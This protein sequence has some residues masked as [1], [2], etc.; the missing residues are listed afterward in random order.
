MR[1]KSLMLLSLIIALI[2]QLQLSACGGGGGGG[3]APGIPRLMIQPDDGRAPILAAIDGAMNN[4][5]LTIYE[6]TD[7]KAVSQNPAAPDDS[8][9]QALIN[10]ARKGVS[11][12]VIV[13]HNQYWSGSS[14]PQVKQTVEAL[15]DAGAIVHIS[16]TAFCFTHQKTFVIDGPTATYSGFFGTAIIMSLN[17]I[18][19]YFVNTRDYAV[20]TSNPGIV[21][22][23]SR[24]FDSDFTLINPPTACVA[25]P[26]PKMTS[27]PPYA[28]DTPFVSENDLLWSPVNSKEKLL[29]LMGSVKKSLVLTTEELTDTDMVC[30][31]QEV[32]QSPS[33]PTVRILLSDDT[34]SSASAV[35]TLL[36]LGLSNLSIRVMPGQ[37]PPADDPTHQTPLYMHGKQVIADGEQAFI[38]SE[39]LTNTSLIQNRELG[40]LITDQAMVARLQSVFESDFTTPNHSLAAKACTEGKGCSKIPCPK[41]L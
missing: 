8:I 37:P 21:Q 25:T 7:L 9:V 2:L 13:D 34:G 36:D 5:R 41:T 27:P 24:V 30:R 6:I 12:Q 10:K 40:I 4:I 20:I 29:Q 33:K 3:A 39:N 35:K 1:Y 32:A 14:S 28:S 15:R 22:E 26:D 16:S 31:I 38:G 11:V 18:P 19:N 23:V 17:L